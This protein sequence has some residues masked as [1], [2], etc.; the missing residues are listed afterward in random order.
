MLGFH[1]NVRLVSLRLKDS[2]R[3]D[4]VAE[5]EDILG[6]VKVLGRD[7]E[8]ATPIFT[9]R[10]RSECITSLLVMLIC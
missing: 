2:S 8:M 7:Q 3:T 1:S 9:K 6:Q 5:Q 10:V 4:T